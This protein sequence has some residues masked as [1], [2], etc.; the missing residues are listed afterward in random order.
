LSIFNPIE[1]ETNQG[2]NEFI[3]V[4][5]CSGSMGGSRIKQARVCLTLFIRSLPPSCFFNVIRF[6]SK[7]KALF[8]EAVQYNTKTAN[9]ASILA[10]SLQANLGGTEIEGPLLYIYKQPLKGVGVRQLFVITD[11]E[12]SNTDRVINIARENASMNR[13]F[14]IGIGSGADAGLVDG[15]AEATGGRSNFVLTD[16]D[17]SG[18]V[19]EQLEASLLPG[20]TNIG[21]EV[22]GQDGVE[23]VPFPIPSVTASV[24]RTIFGSNASQ[25]GSAEVLVTGTILTRRVEERISCSETNIGSAAL[26]ALFAIETIRGYEWSKRIPRERI[27]SLSIT[28]GVLSNETAFIGFSNRVYREQLQIAARASAERWQGFTCSDSAFDEEDFGSCECYESAATAARPSRPSCKH[29]GTDPMLELTALQNVDG[30]WT[31]SKQLQTIARVRVDCP[32]DLRRNPSVFATVLAIAILRTTFT[33]RINQWRMIERK[34]LRWL[35]DQ[36]S[37]AAAEAA[38]DR[39]V[40]LLQ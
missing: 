36:I 9:Q 4:I 31:S 10:E 27:V 21:I 19:I 24:S 38:I 35:K 6:G 1:T 17:L 5:D 28:S 13:C 23:F 40:L 32:S 26:Q 39:L 33:D 18:K 14:T 7:F 16:E 2:N 25:L 22:S 29:P 3:V 37:D 8:P 30:C 34:A 11:G 15:L 12:V 20:L